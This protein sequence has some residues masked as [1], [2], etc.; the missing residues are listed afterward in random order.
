MDEENDR[1]PLAAIQRRTH[2]QRPGIQ[3][4]VKQVVHAHCGDDNRRCLWVFAAGQFGNKLRSVPNADLLRKTRRSKG[5]TAWVDCSPRR[6]KSDTSTASSTPTCSTSGRMMRSGFST[7]SRISPWMRP[8]A[9]M[10][11]VK[12]RKAR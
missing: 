8:L 6:A 3:L 7:A 11:R 4:Q 5:R 10:A 1:V 12:A 9:F 2:L